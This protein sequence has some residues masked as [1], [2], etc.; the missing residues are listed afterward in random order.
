MIVDTSVLI[1]ILRREA[2]YENHIWSL[3]N[4]TGTLSISA[5]T[6]VEAHVVAQRL[7][8]KGLE[9]NLTELI[10]DHGIV[11]EPFAAAHV[12]IAATAHRTY[13]KGNGHPA[14]LNF[15]DCFSYALAKARREPLLFKGNDFAQTDIVAALP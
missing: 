4:A 8:F 10:R 1:A 5:A 12:E 14:Q 15:G 7:K 9:E 6:M 2:G 3:S 11:V 13:G